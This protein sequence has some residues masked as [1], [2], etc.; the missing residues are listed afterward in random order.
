ML[1]LQILENLC[2]MNISLYRLAEFRQVVHNQLR[3]EPMNFSVDT[4]EQ[5]G[6]GANRQLRMTG[7]TPGIIYGKGEPQ[8]VQMRADYG[9]RF[10]KSFKGM[11]QPFELT[12]MNGSQEVKLTAVVQEAQFSNWGERLLHVDFREVDD[13][14]IMK[15]DVPI[16]MVGVC[17]AVKFGGVLQV[18]R[19]QVPIRCKLKDVPEHI[20]V[21]VS[22]LTFGT[23]IH[24][25]ELAYPV[26]VKP[27]VKG[28]NPT[29]CT[30][31]GRKRADVGE[32]DEESTETTVAE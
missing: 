24:M 14:T 31:A 11:I 15:V 12:V 17:P 29:I 25:G 19:R 4:R 18:I 16:E 6:K 28:R 26:G 13:E 3:I 20:E 5:T 2:G 9:T 21:D 10:V 27:V 1:A 23:S 7:L 8:L 30:V 32:E 22:Q